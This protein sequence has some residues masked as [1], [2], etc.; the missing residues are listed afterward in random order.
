MS[1]L[2]LR[3]HMQTSDMLGFRDDAHLLCTAAKAVVQAAKA[4]VEG[5]VTGAVLREEK[6]AAE[7]VCQVFTNALE[8]LP[9]MPVACAC[10][11]QSFHTGEPIACSTQNCSLS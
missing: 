3:P 11:T 6:A 7:A 10:D 4:A 2:H 1:Y 8:V 9:S 5:G